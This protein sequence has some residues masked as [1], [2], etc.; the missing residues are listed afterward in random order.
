MNFDKVKITNPVNDKSQSILLG[1]LSLTLISLAFYFLVRLILFIQAD[2]PPQDKIVAFF[3]LL[4]EIFIL[5]HSVGYFR[6]LIKV[7]GK[8]SQRKSLITNINY[9]QKKLDSYPPVA[10]VVA[11]FREPIHIL[12]QTLTCFY[13]LSYPAKHIYFLDDTR[14]DHDSEFKDSDTNYRKSIDNMC[15]RFGVDLFRRKWRGAKAGMINDF[16]TFI[17]GKTKEGFQFCNF[18]GLERKE[19]EKYIIVFDA[20]QNPFPD[21]V[22]PLIAIM[23]ENPKL[24]FVQTPQ[25]YTNFEMNRVARASG[26]QQVVFFE[27]ICEGKGEQDAMFC[28]GTNVVFRTEALLDVDGLDESSVTEDFATSLHFHL[29]GWQSRYIS[30]VCAFGMGAED[31]GAFFKQQFRW[32]LGCVGNS[33]NIISAFIRN[34]SQL[35]L[36]VWFEYILSGTYYL[37]G[38]AFFIMMLCPI[39]FIFLEVPTFFAYPVFYFLFFGPY[40]ILSLSLFFWTLYK[41]NYLP[42]DIYSGMALIT[43]TFP[44]Y[45]R[46]SLLGLLGWKG[47]FG[48]TP[49]GR[50]KSLPLLRLWP[51]LGMAFIS[52]SAFVWGMLRLYFERDNIW[53]LS[54]NSFWC[55]YF[56]LILSGTLYFN[57]PEVLRNG[58]K[59]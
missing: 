42:R 1:F 36:S 20:D 31:L 58:T 15:R 4:S 22:E 27:Y 3:L 51:Q 55:F 6:N 21:F 41:R 56:F 14:Y 30:K 40:L 13:N 7:I 24:A 59:N 32:A 57:Q 38:W 16:L 19:R 44:V 53:A 37:V 25:Y 9:N 48:V 18:S 46:A 34:P 47:R 33:R 8:G 23:E 52:L 11:S 45:M 5:L 43:I 26:L 10:I 29:R 17:D 2:Y 35:P 49:K 54:L 50:S 12:E 28:C 39:L